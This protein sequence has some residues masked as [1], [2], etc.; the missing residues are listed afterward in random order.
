MGDT[1]FTIPPVFLDIFKKEPRIVLKP[2]PGLWPVDLKVFPL[3]EKMIRDE[4]FNRN[5]EIVIMPRQ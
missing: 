5:F 3:L 1:R 2:W 4:E